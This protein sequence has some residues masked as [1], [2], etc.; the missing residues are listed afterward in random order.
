M[1]VLPR[2]HPH[3][4]KS[5]DEP[6]GPS[7][8]LD[9]G[10]CDGLVP[11]AASCAGAGGCFKS[12]ADW[13]RTTHLTV[14]FLLAVQDAPRVNW[15][16]RFRSTRLDPGRL[17]GISPGRLVYHHYQDFECLIASGSFPTAGMVVVPCSMSTLGAIAAGTTS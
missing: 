1:N 11:L 13:N 9:P 16:W 17:A 12:S 15:G 5:L 2:P 4:R 3:T 8:G 7:A 10:R 6:R 14:I